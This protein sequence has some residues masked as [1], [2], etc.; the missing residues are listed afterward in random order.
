[1]LV[2]ISRK[3]TLKA[4]CAYDISI[5][6]YVDSLTTADE[7]TKKRKEKGYVRIGTI[8]SLASAILAG[9]I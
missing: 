9:Y 8:Y 7:S 4:A 5:L 3:H 1:M 6:T 2:Y